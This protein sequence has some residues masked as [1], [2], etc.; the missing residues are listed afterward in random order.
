MWERIISGVRRLVDVC[1]SLGM[2]DNEGLSGAFI[3]N[4]H[5]DA[6]G[7]EK[8]D[9]TENW[10]DKDKQKQ[11]QWENRKGGHYDVGSKIPRLST[12]IVPVWSLSGEHE[13]D[14]S[15]ACQAWSGEENRQQQL[16]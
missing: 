14:E 15:K 1:S 5:G 13:S 10:K 6:A 8:A 9:E 16:D 11:M 2:E 3:M 7:V 4:T 12:M